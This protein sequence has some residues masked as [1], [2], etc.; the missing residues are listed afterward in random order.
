[1]HLRFN[2]DACPMHS[3]YR[4]VHLTHQNLSARALFCLNSLAKVNTKLLI[5]NLVI[6]FFQLSLS[7]QNLL[8]LVDL[9]FASVYFF[10]FIYYTLLYEV[11]FLITTSIIKNATKNMSTVNFTLMQSSSSLKIKRNSFCSSISK[12]EPCFS[13]TFKQVKQNHPIFR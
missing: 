12:V 5:Y 10:P 2:F 4:F 7:F 6:L 8:N 9:K 1:M 11:I 3:P 13:R